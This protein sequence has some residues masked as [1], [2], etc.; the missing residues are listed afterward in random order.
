M[1]SGENGTN[2][3]NSEGT[4]QTGG[5]Q[6]NIANARRIQELS[7]LA[8]ADRQILVLGATFARWKATG[9]ASAGM[10]TK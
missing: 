3:L 6:S 2:G 1:R 10:P 8:S 5:S 4:N 7:D 9:P